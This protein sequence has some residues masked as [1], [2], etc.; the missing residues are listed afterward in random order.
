MTLGEFAK[1]HWA[2]ELVFWLLEYQ[3]AREHKD[4]PAA[5][6]TRDSFRGLG[7]IIE[8]CRDETV[9][10]PEF[11]VKT[12]FFASVHRKKDSVYLQW[13]H[14]GDK[15]EALTLHYPKESS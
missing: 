1:Q 8:V 12:P 6:F 7:L 4:W 11:P 2:L 13:K 15:T 3:L 14:S 9:V 5:D 10:H